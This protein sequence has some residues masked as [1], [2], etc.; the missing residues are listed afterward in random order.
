MGNR[1]KGRAKPKSQKA[2]SSSSMGSKRKLSRMGKKQKSNH[3]G[4]DAT[5]INRS[6]T[7]RKLGITLKDFQR[8]CILKGVYPREP[9][10]RTP[11]KRKG[12]VYFHIK[13]VRAL[14]HEPILEK[15]REFKAFMKKVRKSAGRNEK[16][17]AA[18]KHAQAPTYT[19]HH[20]VKERYP[21]FIDA[22]SDLDDALTLVYLFAALPSQG[23]ILSRITHSAKKLS[24]AWGAYTALTSSITKSFISVKGVYFESAVSSDSCPPVNIRWIVP[25]AFTQH[26]P[27]DVDYRVMVTFFEFYETY[28]GFVLYKLYSDIGVRYPL[29]VDLGSGGKG[30]KMNLLEGYLNVLTVR[31]EEEGKNI[32]SVVT[33]A[34]EPKKD[35]ET[36]KAKLTKSEKAKQKEL[37][38]TV[39]IALTKI[40]ENDMDEDEDDEDVKVSEPLKQALSN[41]AQEQSNTLPSSATQDLSAEAEQRRRLFANLT[42]FFSREVPRGYLELVSLSYGAKVGWEGEGSP[43]SISDPSITHHVVDRPKLL[44]MYSSLPSRE[45]VQPQWIADCANFK[46]LLPCSRY[47]VGIALPPHLSPWSNEDE[48]EGYTPPFAKEV[49][50]L[51]NGEIGTLSMEETVKDQNDTPVEKDNEKEDSDD[52][53]DSDEKTPNDTK[54]QDSDVEEEEDEDEENAHEKSNSTSK[55]DEEAKELAKLVMSKKATRLY[56]RMKKGQSQKQERIEILQRK[57]REIDES[58]DMRATGAKSNKKKKLERLKDERKD[59]EKEYVKQTGRNR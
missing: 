45:F 43:L 19:L 39:G 3:S 34:A 21:R 32:T 25:H 37:I 33:A 2:A 35:E 9:R 24:A 53:S 42:F 12:L 31:N 51:K 38:Q 27:K 15:F 20:L 54:K 13:D 29:E 52:D 4:L 49:E 10:G 30:L 55:M 8:L 1:V 46:F 36:K 16:D 28:L 7:L 59:L 58:K 48:E 41:L 57:R 26:L 44:P 6:A 23:R 5:F 22:L 18:R 40:N 50:R 14:A 11:N 56:G 17:E 47:G